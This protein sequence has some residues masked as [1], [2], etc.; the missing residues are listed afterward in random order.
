MKKYDKY[1]NEIIE[2][3]SEGYRNFEIANK[4]NIDSRR[5]GEALKENGLISNKRK[6]NDKPT[7]KEEKIF[8]YLKKS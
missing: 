4:I 3:H 6:F 8:I 5:V 1:I 7:P 2:L